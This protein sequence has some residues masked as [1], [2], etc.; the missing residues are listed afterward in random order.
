MLVAGAKNS[1]VTATIVEPR[2][3]EARSNIIIR[4]AYTCQTIRTRK[5]YT[6]TLTQRRG[7]QLVIFDTFVGSHC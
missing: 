2:A 7:L 3:E 1:S 6:Y 5:H 4:L